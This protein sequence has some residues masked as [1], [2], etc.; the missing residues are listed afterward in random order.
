MLNQCQWAQTG[1]Q[2]HHQQSHHST[3][4]H[5]LH[6]VCHHY[7]LLNILRGHIC[8]MHKLGHLEEAVHQGEGWL[9]GE[10][11]IRIRDLMMVLLVEHRRGGEEDIGREVKL[12][13]AGGD[14][15]SRR[16]IGVRPTSDEIVTYV[17]LSG[18]TSTKVFAHQH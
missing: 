10:D 1:S 6:R 16:G 8:L 4:Q 15:R 2:C 17:M 9:V 3:T 13:G 14:L 5:P 18:G 12:R 7:R 11:L